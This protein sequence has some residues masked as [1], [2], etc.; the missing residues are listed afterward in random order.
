MDCARSQTAPTVSSMQFDVYTM[1]FSNRSWEATLE[2]LKTFGIHRLV[3]IRTLPGSKHT[4]QF[5]L[6]H[7]KDELPKA[8]IDYVHLKGL[9]GFRKPLKDSLTNAAWQNSGFRGYADYMQ[10]EA[11]DVALRQ[12]LEL[13]NEKRTVYCCTE[14]VFWRCHRQLVSDALLVRGYHVGHIF[15]L[16]KTEPHKLTGSAR[17]EGEKITYPALPL[18]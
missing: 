10:T 16:T 8:G 5:N 7:L 14:A 9:G 11:F 4:P 18:T 6:E 3:D 17:I 12:L 2:I 13:L 15:T 1:G